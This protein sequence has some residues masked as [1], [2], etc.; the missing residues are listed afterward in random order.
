VARPVDLL[1]TPRG[2][3]VPTVESKLPATVWGSEFWDAASGASNFVETATVAGAGSVATVDSLGEIET[4][5]AAGAGAVAATDILTGG[6]FVYTETATVAGDGAV[7]ATDSAGRIEAGTVAGTGTLSASDG[8][9]RVEIG[10]WSGAGAVV[11]TDA[12]ALLELGLVAGSGAV[13]AVDESSI[14]PITDTPSR[15]QL[16][17]VRTGTFVP[18]WRRQGMLRHTGRR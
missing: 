18:W 15:W 6:G 7:S 14:A 16:P 9:Q 12:V 5:T 3:L 2:A 8:S 4:A 1:I 10:S 13:V 17:R 11:I